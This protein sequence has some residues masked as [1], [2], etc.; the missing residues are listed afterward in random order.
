MRAPP[1]ARGRAAAR[2]EGEVEERWF[3]REREYDGYIVGGA[4]LG[5]GM[6]WDGYDADVGLTPRSDSTRYKIE[7]MDELVT[8]MQFV[9]DAMRVPFAAVPSPDPIDVSGHDV[10]EVEKYPEYRPSGLTDILEA[11]ADRRGMAYVNLFDP[12]QTRASRELYLQGHDPHWNDRGQDYAAK[13]ATE[14]LASN[15]LLDEVVRRVVRSAPGP[16]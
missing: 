6:G 4:S 2:S 9:A 5:R 11:I 7:L 1:S 15:G 14:F 3:Q 10:R 13:V 16:G 8:R 12:F